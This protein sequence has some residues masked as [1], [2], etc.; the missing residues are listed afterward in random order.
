M[1]TN[2]EKPR[3]VFLRNGLKNKTS[4][5]FFTGATIWDNRSYLSASFFRF[6]FFLFQSSF[7]GSCFS[8]MEMK[9]EKPKEV[10]APDKLI[11]NNLL[12]FVHRCHRLGE[13]E[14]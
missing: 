12:Q 5:I 2:F 1:K 11:Y 13:T 14:V 10:F 4:L 7:C 8:E 9:L 6:A 3:E